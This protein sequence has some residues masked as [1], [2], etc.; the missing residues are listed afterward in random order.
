MYRIA[1]SDVEELRHPGSRPTRRSTAGLAHPL[2]RPPFGTE[3]H[4]WLNRN[5]A[6]EYFS[7]SL[8]ALADPPKEKYSVK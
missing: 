1:K 7:F 2:F 8:A 4:P 3:P 5:P 6:R